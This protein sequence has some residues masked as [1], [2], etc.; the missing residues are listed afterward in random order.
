M[1]LRPAQLSSGEQQLVVLAYEIIFR[2]ERETLV[3]ID[4]PEIS[5]HI[6]WQDSLI[7]DLQRIGK[8]SQL[9]FLMATHSPAILAANPELE[10][11]LDI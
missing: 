3:I 4:E 1:L 11:P 6:M 5:L 9:Q 7:S 8:P 2:T 10:R